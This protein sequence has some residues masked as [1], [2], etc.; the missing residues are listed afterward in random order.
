MEFAF[1][2]PQGPESVGVGFHALGFA[3]GIG[4]FD[5]AGGPALGFLEHIVSAF[6]ELA[7]VEPFAELVLGLGLGASGL[8]HGVVNDLVFLD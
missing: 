7:L 3:L 5:Q 6:V 2:G 1:E 8:D 4:L